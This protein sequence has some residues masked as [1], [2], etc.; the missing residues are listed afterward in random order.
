[1]ERRVQRLIAVL[2][3]LVLT[4]PSGSLLAATPASVSGIVVAA[5]D[6]TPVP[7]ARVFAGDPASGRVVPSAGTD[8]AG[9][10]TIANLEPGR[11]ELAVGVNDGLY[12]VR[13][14]LRLRAGETR[15]MTLAVEA[16]A[17]QTP[18]PET[19]VP[20]DTP[21]PPEGSPK[22]NQRH[23][24]IWSNP[25]TAALIVLGSAIVIGVLVENAT[26]DDDEVPAS[27]FD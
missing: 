2:V 21:P 11:Y 14:P 24:T 27:P 8:E 18:D 20:D 26:D 25:L 3:L 6:R 10:F 7:G 13:T 4:L 5:G 23:P 15:S 12:P 9:R 16:Q 22:P 17:G 1:M 19:G